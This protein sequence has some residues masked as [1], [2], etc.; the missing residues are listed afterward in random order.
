M[1]WT[2]KFTGALQRVRIQ[3]AL[4]RLSPQK[5]SAS[6]QEILLTSRPSL[7]HTSPDRALKF[8]VYFHLPH[9]MAPKPNLPKTANISRSGQ[10]R[11]T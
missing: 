1:S 3:C 6:S 4:C 5:P 9:F 7:Q 8:C 11:C 2:S 10:H